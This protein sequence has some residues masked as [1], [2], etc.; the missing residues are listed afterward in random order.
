MILMQQY[1]VKYE[2][3]IA[4][5][6][7]AWFDGWFGSC[8]SGTL[9]NDKMVIILS[10]LLKWVIKRRDYLQDT[11]WSEISLEKQYKMRRIEIPHVMFGLGTTDLQ[12]LNA[13]AVKQDETK[14]DKIFLQEKRWNDM[15]LVHHW[16]G[17]HLKIYET[18]IHQNHAAS[19]VPSISHGRQH[20]WTQ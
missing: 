10:V 17:A 6:C 5:L 11:R 9:S 14:W 4:M 8:K 2:T 12:N 16:D 7:D 1:N 13:C 19:V 18:H 20:T 15:K 3:G